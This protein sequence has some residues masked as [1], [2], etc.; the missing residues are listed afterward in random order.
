MCPLDDTKPNTNPNPNTNS[1]PNRNT[2]PVS[3]FMLFFE[4]GP[5]IFSLAADFI[6][7][8]L[9]FIICRKRQICFLSHSLGDFG[10]TYVVRNLSVARW[11][12]RGRLPIRD[13]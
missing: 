9:N 1:N 3:C 5:L 7:H 2:N 13:N 8:K 6:Q 11:K 10:V 12:A 4:H